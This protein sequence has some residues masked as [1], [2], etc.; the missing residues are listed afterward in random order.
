MHLR[1]LVPLIGSTLAVSA[2]PAAPA[3]AESHPSP[4][5]SHSLTISV[6]ENPIVEGQPIVIYGRL[7]AGNDGDRR[8]VLYHR[9]DY[10][11]TF[12]PVQ[13]TTTDQ[14]G[15][16]AFTRLPEKV[17]SNRSWYVRSLGVRSA[18]VREHV[19]AQ[20]SIAG[21]SAAGSTVLTGPHD[22][23]RFSGT[24][25]PA[26]VGQELV[27]QRQEANGGEDWHTIQRGRVGPGGQYAFVHEFR[28]PG[29]ANIRVLLRADGLNIASPSDVLAYEIEQAENP[30]L[31]IESSANPLVIGQPETISGALEGS[32]DA[33][34]TLY[35]RTAG[36]LFAALATTTTG[37]DGEYAFPAQTPQSS[38]A[39]QVRSSS[40]QSNVL[41]V[42]VKYVVSAG[43]AT[44][45][46]AQGQ[47]VTLSGSV[48]PTSPGHVVDLQQQ[49]ASGQWVTV[50][51][52]LTSGESTFTLSRPLFVTGIV[53]LR[54]FVPG[55][56]SNQ[57]SASAPV[58]V[59]VTPVSAGQLPEDTSSDSPATGLA[60]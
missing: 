27:L 60:E 38:T 33:S 20:L 41:F 39:Y 15:Y 50:Q 30:A 45:S 28:Y 59:T 4:N 6:S 55:G 35:G 1:K 13:Q 19:Y 14:S 42:G 36:G 56:P 57:G 9:G 51:R 18:T 21:S 48:A 22:P 11:S 37:Q 24:V 46:I 16:Y 32:A 2:L 44:T 7:N 8:V 23:V 40:V 17:I 34:V 47:L 26:N 54:A 52:S 12:T 3:L 29:D 25:T 49:A 43:T 5:G 53:S 10:S 58:V 31:T